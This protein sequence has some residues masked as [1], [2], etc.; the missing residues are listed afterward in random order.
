[1]RDLAAAASGR[2]RHALADS[3]APIGTARKAAGLPSTKFPPFL[4]TA[5][6]DGQRG[7]MTKEGAC[8]VASANA[9]DGEGLM[10]PQSTDLTQRSRDG[11]CH[12]PRTVMVRQVMSPRAILVVRRS[13]VHAGRR[14]MLLAA[15]AAC[16]SA[17]ACAG[18]DTPETAA[19]R[20][21][22]PPRVRRRRSCRDCELR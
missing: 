8:A 20:L 19:M 5:D 13:V 11:A 4:L 12:V 16:G 9:I 21:L 7:A 2:A 14:G 15:V 22:R 18:R 6:S 17:V 1:M 3:I 10:C